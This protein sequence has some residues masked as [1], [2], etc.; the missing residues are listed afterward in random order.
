L[1][2]TTLASEKAGFFVIKGS[3]MSH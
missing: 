2:N 3:G 1:G